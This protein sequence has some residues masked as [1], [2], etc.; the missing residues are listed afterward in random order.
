MCYGTCPGYIVEVDRDGRVFYEGR[1][2]VST[3]GKAEAR[4]D[5]TALAALREAIAGARLAEMPEHCCDCMDW[6]DDA[7]VLVTAAGEDG[8]RTIADY[9]G[10]KATPDRLRALER[11]IDEIVG[12]KRWVEGWWRRRCRW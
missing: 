5:A 6:T 11:Q 10:C 3:C 7:T 4:L 8:A 12:T 2:H 1:I 9:H